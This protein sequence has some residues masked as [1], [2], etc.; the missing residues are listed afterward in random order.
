MAIFTEGSILSVILR[1]GLSAILVIIAYVLTLLLHSIFSIP[2][3]GNLLLAWT[4]F[5]WA[6]MGSSW[7]LG[8][9]P[10]ITAVILSTL[11][12]GYHFLPPYD[13]FTVS[14]SELPI[15][16]TFLMFSI[17]TIWVSNM[18]KVR[19]VALKRAGEEIDE[20]AAEINTRNEILIA[21]IVERKRVEGELLEHAQ[22]LD[23]THDTIFVRD[24]NYVITYWNR[25]AE[26]LYG[27]KREEAVGK[28]AQELI[29]TTFPAPLEEIMAKLVRTGRWEGE[30][31]HTKRDGTNVVV[32]SRWS[33]QNDAHGNPIAI[34]ETNND[35]TERKR[36]EEALRRNEAYLEEAQRIAH[37]G[38]WDRDLDTDITTWSD[39][40]CLIFGLRPEERILTVSRVRELIH[41][42][43]R[44]MVGEKVSEALKGGARYDV[45]YRVV[46][47]NGEVRIVH[48]KGIINMDESGRPR[49]MFGA[50]QDIT[51][52]KRAEDEIRK[53]NEEL[54]QKVIERTSELEAANKELEAFAYSVSH[55]LRAPLRHMAGYS[56]LLQ[57]NIVST[58]D[59]KG[60]RYMMIIQESAK[61]MGNLIDDLLDFSRVGRVEMQ[62]T[63]VS[64]D[65]LVKEAL[66]ELKEETDGRHI[67]WRIGTL[68][69]VYADRSML[70]LALVN[71]ISNAIKF[72]SKR[73]KTEI[74]IGSIERKE[75]GIVVFIKDNGIGFDMKYANKLFGV[76]QRLHPAE[77]FEG[78][79]IGLANVQ[80]IIHR[81]GGRIW[82]EGIVDRGATFYFS[83][84]KS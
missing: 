84:P 8:K 42:E 23:L 30:L 78:T 37:V 17:V 21:E 44:L 25:G 3:M 54:E 14:P 2:F 4:I 32:A 38:Y 33:L 9:G 35:I 70:M 20:R 24:L 31:V 45:E 1:F 40:T 48:S 10:G 19:E 80:R 13:K 69:N 28:V 12:I 43:D 49:Q 76:F 62:K 51:E 15:L 81:H 16:V 71:L 41:P 55:D 50:V 26:V 34:L 66:N 60:R 77:E 47:P 83:V 74:E 11:V 7:F 6:I 64:L 65:Q 59:E 52:R 82:A 29:E 36:I 68:P 79:G 46:R 67:D 63:M 75:D 18:L 57:K 56:E 5:I 72:T 27:W 58:L 39:E 22:L 61:R 73:P 53:L